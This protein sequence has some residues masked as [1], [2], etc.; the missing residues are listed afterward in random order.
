MHHRDNMTRKELASQWFARLAAL[1]LILAPM[2]SMAIPVT[3]T[4]T[5]MSWDY[6]PFSDVDLYGP[7][8]RTTWELSFDS[9]ALSDNRLTSREMISWEGHTP[10]FGVSSKTC[11][12][13]YAPCN[14]DLS[15]SFHPESLEV[16]EYLLKAGISFNSMYTGSNP[17]LINSV[18]LYDYVYPYGNPDGGSTVPGIWEVI[19]IPAPGNI[20]LFGPILL[21][22]V[23]TRLSLTR[24]S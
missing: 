19:H 7:D 18:E 6:E 22:L 2:P 21:G 5:G 8:D 13:P 17:L 20:W 10:Y 11:L 23:G 12:D 15:L 4:Y 3:M 16:T 14:W 1:L 9:S 24:R